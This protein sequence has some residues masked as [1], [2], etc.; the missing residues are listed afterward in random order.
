[1]CYVYRLFS[2][3]FQIFYLLFGYLL[4][5]GTYF[6]VLSSFRCVTYSKAEY[7]GQE[8]F[9]YCKKLPSRKIAYLCKFDYK[10]WGKNE[11]RHVGPPTR[12]T[13]DRDVNNEVGRTRVG[14][15][16]KSQTETAAASAKVGGYLTSEGQSLAKFPGQLPSNNLPS[17]PSGVFELRSS[18]ETTSGLAERAG[19]LRKNPAPKPPVQ[20]TDRVGVSS[21]G[22][23][24]PRIESEERKKQDFVLPT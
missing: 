2:T 12:I 13:N 9:L 1:M 18:A 23:G 6:N 14:F 4:G 24:R 3:N 16:G 7:V 11:Q 22:D 5:C 19:T 8:D 10:N 21:G 20:P 17:R 15:V